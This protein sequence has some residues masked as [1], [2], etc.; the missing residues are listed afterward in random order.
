MLKKALELDQP[1]V[2][3]HRG[4]AGLVPENTLPSFAMAL[5]LGA[6]V[7]E[8]DVHATSDGII[9]VHHDV[10]VERTTDGQG[11][12]ADFSFGDLCELDAGYQYTRGHDDYPYRGHGLQIPTLEEV[13]ESFPDV[14]CNMEVKPPGIAA[15]VV[16]IIRAAGA[17]DRVLLA[18]EHDE[19]M[20]EIRQV[21]EGIPTSFATG[22]VID[23]VDR[24][25][26]GRF[27]GYAP[28][29]TALQIPPRY[30]DVELVT[31]ET[32]AAAHQ[33]GL[34]IHVW[35]INQLDEMQDLLRMGVDGIMSD[36][37]GLAR[38]AVDTL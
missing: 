5:A 18:A 37:P 23:F 7:L 11:P 13:F 32:I 29:G 9:V 33:H 27:E 2:F 20:Q 19:I 30:G 28:E 17:A 6:D 36:L 12:L 21:G 31:P 16:K 26:N 10:T 22:E 25:Q 24:F 15:E 8:L 4:A 34:E 14:P 3:G 38:V 1:L 35:T